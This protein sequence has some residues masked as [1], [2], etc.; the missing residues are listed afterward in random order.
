MGFDTIEINL[1]FFIFRPANE[2]R[3]KSVGFQDLFE[4]FFSTWSV[5]T[6]LFYMWF[7]IVTRG[8]KKA[9]KGQLDPGNYKDPK[10]RV[11]KGCLETVLKDTRESHVEVLVTHLKNRQKL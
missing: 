8:H 9:P 6:P 11:T 4:F 1:V 5:M 3:R 7:N 2:K 10:P